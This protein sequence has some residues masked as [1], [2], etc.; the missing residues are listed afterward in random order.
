MHETIDEFFT[1]V[2][3]KNINLAELEEEQILQ[4][5]SCIIDEE[6]NL[7]KNLFLKLL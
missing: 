3:K 4:I 2:K 1:Y 7:S 6:L 5:V